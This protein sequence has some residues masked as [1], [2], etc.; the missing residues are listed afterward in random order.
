MGLF[1]GLTPTLGLQTV[2]II[3]GCVV[4][5]G[6][7]FIALAASWISNPVTIV[8]LYL[9]FHALGEACFRTL[10]LF[11]AVP[12]VSLLQE[13][14]DDLIFTA[15]GSLVTAF[16]VSSLGYF[17]TLRWADRFFRQ[18]TVSSFRDGK[19]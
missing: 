5:R 12:P 8:P 9:F 3:I 17:A 13:A 14:C 2:L 15:L 6:N 1:I 16:P 11:A 19:W 7:V 10:P 18:K 4:L